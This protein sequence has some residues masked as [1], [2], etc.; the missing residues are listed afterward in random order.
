M[1]KGYHASCIMLLVQML[2]IMGQVLVSIALSFRP[3]HD[4]LDGNKAMLNQW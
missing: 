2:K 4:S 1:V 3:I